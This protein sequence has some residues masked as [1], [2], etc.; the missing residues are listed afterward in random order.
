VYLYANANPIRWFD[1]LGL[2]E[3]KVNKE[4]ALL[5][6]ELRKLAENDKFAAKY[7]GDQSAV[8][9]A[10]QRIKEHI[11]E[12]D[13]AMCCGGGD[14]GDSSNDVAG[15]TGDPPV[16]TPRFEPRPPPDVPPPGIKIEIDK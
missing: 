6:E 8:D 4:A 9:N 5:A 3:C 1:L 16:K 13:K 2:D 12:Y 11:E 7:Y 10:E 14:D 15:N